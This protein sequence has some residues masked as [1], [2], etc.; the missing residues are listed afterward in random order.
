MR[1]EEVK[2][3]RFHHNTPNKIDLTVITKTRTPW[4]CVIE[5][6]KMLLYST[7]NTVQILKMLVIGST[8]LYC[9]TVR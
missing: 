7:C 9:N 1:N 8:V 6:L 2:F 5:L 3:H 4:V